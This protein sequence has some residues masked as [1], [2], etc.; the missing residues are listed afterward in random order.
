MPAAIARDDTFV[1]LVK[2]LADTDSPRLIENASIEHALTIIECLLDAA[3]KHKEK[4]RIVSGCL[5]ESF[6][7]SLVDKAREVM[8]AGVP[9]SVVVLRGSKE[10]LRGN[11][12]C[13]VVDK[14]QNGE[15]HFVDGANKTLH[16]VVTG[17]CRY[18]VEV[19]DEKKKA[20]ASFNDRTIG[21]G[22]VSIYE[23]LLSPA[24]AAG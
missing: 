2:E 14:D 4:V 15:V 7:S 17:D 12:F 1:R 20:I 10:D 24:P 18:R 9:I 8:Q 6:Y 21:R 23:D 16:F 13:N 11:S 22:L 5:M 3:K 19:D